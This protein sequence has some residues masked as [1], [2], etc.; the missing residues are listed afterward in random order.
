MDDGYSST[1]HYS[2]YLLAL[3]TLLFVEKSNKFCQSCGMPMKKDELGGGTLT[4]GTRTLKF[5]SRC[6]SQGAF[7]RPDLTIQEM[8]DLVKG[9]MKEM[10]FPGFLSFIFTLQIPKL[11]RWRKNLFYVVISLRKL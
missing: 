9:K 8:K 4:D 1:K 2:L 5:C 11:E 7:T 10:G 3:L 6:Y